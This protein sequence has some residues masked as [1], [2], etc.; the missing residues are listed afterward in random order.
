[1]WAIE[2]IV[3]KG[4]YNYAI[5][6]NHPKRTK[7]DYVLEHRV[8][9]ENNIGRLLLSNEVVHHING[10]YKD[11]RIE[12]LQVMTNSEHTK[13]HGKQIL[14]KWVQ[15]KCPICGGVFER[16]H[17]KTHLSKHN[18]TTTCCSRLCGGK[19]SMMRHFK[20]VEE[21]DTIIV[22]NVIKIFMK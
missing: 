9:V 22:D 6:R 4:K 17:S 3:S 7:N 21:S 1:M 15:L 16:K 5:V 10:K 13:L 18:S 20:R 2:K 8:I 19:M 14:R 12:N 11:N